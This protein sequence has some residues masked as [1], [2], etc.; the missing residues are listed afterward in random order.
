MN[1]PAE[2]Q[3]EPNEQT[4]T[5][6]EV[7]KGLSPEVQARV[8]SLFTRMAYKY[9]LAQCGLLADDREVESGVQ[10]RES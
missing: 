1:E 5:P 3:D 6:A 4:V 8:V 7:W 10:G 2:Q 9:A